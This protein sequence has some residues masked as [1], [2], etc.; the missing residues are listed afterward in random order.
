M[1]VSRSLPPCALRRAGN[2]IDIDKGRVEELRRG[3]DVAA[4]DLARPTLTYSY[5]PKELQAADFFIVTVPTPVDEARHPDMG[6]V[7]GASET[8]GRALGK[9]DIVVYESTVYPGA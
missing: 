7:F 1:S 2:R 6:A 9:G 5:D 4:A 3:H 8:V